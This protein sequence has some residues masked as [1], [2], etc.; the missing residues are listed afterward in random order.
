MFGWLRECASGPVYP[1]MASLTIVLPRM[2]DDPNED[3]V[4]PERQGYAHE[5]DFLRAVRIAV[6]AAIPTIT[7]ILPPLQMS[8]CSLADALQG[9]VHGGRLVLD[10]SHFDVHNHSRCIPFETGSP[11]WVR[12]MQ[13]SGLHL[14]VDNM[15]VNDSF[16]LG[17]VCVLGRIIQIIGGV[18]MVNHN[19][20]DGAQMWNLL[21][22]KHICFP[23]CMAL[24]MFCLGSEYA[25]G[26]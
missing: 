17:M 25:N 11:L 24:S 5:N 4:S 21:L 14:N 22:G 19:H 9:F 16:A 10:L 20:Y 23:S 18:I 6:A 1:P 7:L 8:L 2:P 3:L 26:E 12:L 13:L 15:R